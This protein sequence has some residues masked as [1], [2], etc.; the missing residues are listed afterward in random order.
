MHTINLEIAVNEILTAHRGTATN[1]CA[2]CREYVPSEADR[3]KFDDRELTMRHQ[4]S[5]VAKYIQEVRANEIE[6]IARII[7]HPTITPILMERAETTRK[8]RI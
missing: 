1:F 5:M 6:T 4:A 2:T 7:G 8:G 3:E